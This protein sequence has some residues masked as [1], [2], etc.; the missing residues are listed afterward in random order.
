MSP[1]VAKFINLIAWTS[2]KGSRNFIFASTQNNRP[3]SYISACKEV[4]VSTFVVSAKGRETQAKY[5]KEAV[6][7]LRKIAPEMDEVLE[8]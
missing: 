6:D 2:E 8:S 4:P 5:W 3:G 7:I 1:L